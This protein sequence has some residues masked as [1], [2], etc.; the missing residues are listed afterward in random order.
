MEVHPWLVRFNYLRLSVRG[1]IWD[2]AP[3]P[4]GFKNFYNFY[5]NPL[6][7]V[8]VKRVSP[9]SLG[10]ALA[11]YRHMFPSSSHSSPGSGSAGKKKITAASQMKKAFNA[12]CQFNQHRLN[13]SVMHIEKHGRPPNGD[14]PAAPCH[15]KCK[16]RTRRPWGPRAHGTDLRTSPGAGGA[17]DMDHK[18]LEQLQRTW[19]TKGLNNCK[20]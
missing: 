20:F 9:L 6:E 4:K 3:L 18:G 7:G 19:I 12:L 10:N 14:R 8:K 5:P 16:S 13:A 2:H 11:L 1:P 17:K 15:K